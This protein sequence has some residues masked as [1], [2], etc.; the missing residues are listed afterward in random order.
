MGSSKHQKVFVEKSPKI[1]K[2]APTHLH[3]RFFLSA[4]CIGYMEI[5]NPRG[6][7]KKKQIGSDGH[8][9]DSH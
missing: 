2:K 5:E 1:S 3:G 6:A 4:P 8:L 9:A 7:L